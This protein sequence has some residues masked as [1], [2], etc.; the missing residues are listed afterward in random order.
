MSQSA[1][2]RYEPAGEGPDRYRIELRMRFNNV[3][4][5]GLLIFFGSLVF[6]ALILNSADITEYQTELTA[7]GFAA[8]VGL[9]LIFIGRSQHGT[10]ERDSD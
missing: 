4:R 10:M 8:L 7:F 9:L 5:V 6:T 3:G 2:D 1:D